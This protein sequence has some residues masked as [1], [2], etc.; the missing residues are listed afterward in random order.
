MSF[1]CCKRFSIKKNA[2][3]ATKVFTLD[4]SKKTLPTNVRGRARTTLPGLALTQFDCD[5]SQ[6]VSG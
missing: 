5:R 4:G 3:P 6:F 2:N 1:E